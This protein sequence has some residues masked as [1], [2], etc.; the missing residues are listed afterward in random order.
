MTVTY[1]LNQILAEYESNQAL[2]AFSWTVFP[3]INPDGYIYTQTDRMWRKN[4]RKNNALCFG[5]D[6]NRNW[7]NHFNQGG[8]S[9]NPCS[10][11][12]CGPS[13]FS[14]PEE[15]ALANY[16]GNATNVQGYIDFH[17]YSQLWMT[18]WGWTVQKPVDYNTQIAGAN[19]AVKALTAVYGTQYTTGDIYSTIYEA[20]GSSVDYTYGNVDIKYSYAVELRDQGQYGFLLPPNQILPSGKETFAGLVALA[21]YVKSQL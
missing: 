13:P 1:M 14:E 19:A 12:Y 6:T 8:S 11:T 2:S 5:V 10:E 9:T 20:T 18:P 7:N 4:R 3:V 21:Q 15:T 17:S 16:L